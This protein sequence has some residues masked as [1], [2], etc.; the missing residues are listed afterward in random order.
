[1]KKFLALLVAAGL[2]AGYGCTRSAP[3]PE[4]TKPAEPEKP[5]MEEPAPAPAE[6]EE[7]APAEG[8]AEEKVEEE[9]TET[10]E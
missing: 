5:A 7:A 4:E 6:T 9:G 2:F 8:E 1:M 10:T 3:K